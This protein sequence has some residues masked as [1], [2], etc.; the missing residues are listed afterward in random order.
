MTEVRLIHG[1][2]LHIPGEDES[3][4]TCVTSPPCDGFLSLRSIPPLNSR[5]APQPRHLPAALDA[6][7]VSSSQWWT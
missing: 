5:S 2:A 6:T 7:V 3:V 1:S 4:Q